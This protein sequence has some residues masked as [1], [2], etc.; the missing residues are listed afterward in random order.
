[1][2]LHAT[3]RTRVV[4]MFRDA[5]GRLTVAAGIGDPL[6]RGDPM[7]ARRLA[8]G[9]PDPSYAGGGRRVLDPTPKVDELF[10]A[11]RTPDG[12]MVLLA[13]SG[14][15]GAFS[16][17]RVGPDGHLVPSFGDHGVMVDRFASRLFWGAIAV[18][19]DGRILVSGMTL[20]GTGTPMRR[21]R[22]NGALDETF[23]DG[24]RLSA[25]NVQVDSIVLRTDDRFVVVGV[26]S[27]IP[28]G[29]FVT[30]RQYSPDGVLDRA[31]GVDGLA[32]L[33]VDSAIASVLGTGRTVLDGTGRLIVPGILYD[34]QHDR[35][36]AMVAVM[37]RDG[38]TRRAFSDDGWTALD[39]GRSDVFSAAA[40][41]PYGGGILVVG[42]TAD[43]LN[44]D[45][46]RTPGSLVAAVYRRDGTLDPSFGDGGRV[47]TPITR[48]AGYAVAMAVITDV[49]TYTVAGTGGGDGIVARFRLAPE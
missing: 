37:N 2:F 23:A 11:A 8:D 1:M 9:S 13:R 21:Y 14:S 18:Q 45:W 47:L 48:G 35:S 33:K 38:S 19:R 4:A 43:A 3:G 36:D 31:F 27:G 44:R 26:D 28:G 39:I 30:A 32:T 25:R 22:A 29:P 24:G 12:G 41:L 15:A 6:K 5:Q 20:T 10:A 40:A 17:T 42:G 16:V 34:P 46:L 49:A 7:I